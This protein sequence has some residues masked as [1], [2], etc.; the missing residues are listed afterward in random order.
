M[1]NEIA[2]KDE[3]SS[4]TLIGK[5]LTSGEIRNAVIDD[6]TNSLVD[7]E[8]SHAKIHAGTHYQYTDYNTIASAGTQD[9]MFTTGATKPPHLTFSVQGTLLTTV[10]LFE[11][12]DKTGTTLQTVYNNNRLSTNTSTS[13]IHK[14][15]SGGTTDGTAIFSVQGGTATGAF[16]QSAFSR[17]ENE[18]VLK[19][20][21]KYI[22]RATSGA[23]GNVVAVVLNWYEN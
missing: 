3:N 2:K 12:S 22:L 7:I 11:A 16:A 10:T 20:N 8:V 6:Y 17:S 15:T 9:Y 4:S 21:T 19:L 1:A 23:N 18:Y 14:G 5:A 13:T